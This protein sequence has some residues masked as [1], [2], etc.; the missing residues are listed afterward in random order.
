MPLVSYSLT[1]KGHRPM[2]DLY[3]RAALAGNWWPL[4][5]VVVGSIIVAVLVLLILRPLVLWYFRIGRRE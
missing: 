2:L 1:T 5:V 3:W 4:F